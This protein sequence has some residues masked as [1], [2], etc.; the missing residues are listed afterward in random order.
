M[1]FASLLNISLFAEIEAGVKR[2]RITIKST[3][4]AAQDAA[5]A[6]EAQR[7]VEEDR[8]REEERKKVAEKKRKDE[9]ERKGKE[10]EER[11]RK[12]EEERRKKAEEER[13][14]EAAKKKTLEKELETKK[15]MDQP[16]IVQGPG[17]AEPAHSAPV[18]TSKGSRRHRWGYLL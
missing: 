7:K 8:K 4:A 1:F 18:I 3:D 6:A 11:Q 17:V 2:P 5:K 9:E 16:L 12:A 14:A 10:E 15:A 13:L